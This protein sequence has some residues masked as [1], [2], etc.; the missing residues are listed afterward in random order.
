LNKKAIIVS[1]L[2]KGNYDRTLVAKEYAIATKKKGNMLQIET[3][4]LG[5]CE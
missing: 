2:S 4:H 1:L 5:D 3:S